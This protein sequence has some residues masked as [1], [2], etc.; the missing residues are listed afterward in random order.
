MIA[1]PSNTR[2][3]ARTRILQAAARLYY[4]EGIHS[5][6]I[7]RVVREADVAKAT[8]YAH[9]PGKDALVASY[10]ALESERWWASVQSDEVPL[11]GRPRI[12]E[13]FDL[14][15][16]SAEEPR[17]RGCPFINAGAEFPGPGPVT[18]QIR[19]HRSRVRDEFAR[20]LADEPQKATLVDAILALY[21]GAMTA[22]YIDHR[23]EIILH[24][25]DAALLLLD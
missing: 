3:D 15:H 8:L 6:G 2:N 4:A 9:F 11:S 22:A 10:L 17:Y 5:V 18:E 21:G 14:L 12:R 23:P 7:E 1:D 20:A 16:Q 24:A 13:L 19:L 25:R